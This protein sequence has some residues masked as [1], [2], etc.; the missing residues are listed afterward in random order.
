M[1]DETEGKSSSRDKDY[2]QQKGMREQLSEVY[3]TV[4]KG[5]DDKKSQSD[6]IR[7]CWDVYNCNI[8]DQQAYNGSS[9]VFIPLVHDAVEAQVTRHVNTLFPPTGRAV[10]V[11]SETGDIPHALIAMQEHYVRKAGVRQAVESM[12]RGGYV[13]GQFSLYLSWKERTRFVTSKV[14][15]AAAQTELGT[16]IEGSEFE[17]IDS[18]RELKQ[19]TPDVMVLATEDL[20]ILPATADTIEDAELVAVR[21]RITKAALK[22]KIASGEYSKDAEQ[23]LAQFGATARNQ[24]PDPDKQANDAAGVKVDGATKFAVVYE[25]WTKLKVDGER[26]WCVVDFGGS[27]LVLRCK[28]NPY[29]CD[30]VPVLSLPRAK[31]GGSIWGQSAIAG[32]VEKL[33]YTAND[34]WNMG[35]DSAQYALLPIVMT[36]PEKNPRVGSMVL[37]MAAIWETS[38]NDTKFAAFPQLWKDALQLVAV[39]RDQIMQS[40]SVNPA[41]MPHGNAGKKPSAAQA[42]QET[43]Q[44]VENTAMPVGDLEASILAPMLQWFYDLDAQ[45]RDDELMVETF[46]ELGIQARMQMVPAQQS[47]ERYLFKWYGS[48]GLRSAQQIQQMIA[49]MNVLRGV[50]PDQLGGRRFDIAP[51]M[52]HIVETVFGPRLAPRILIDQRDQLSL[53][54]ALENQMLLNNLPVQVHML[55]DDAQHLQEHNAAAMATGDPQG[56][57]RAHMAQH[58][59][60]LQ[61]KAGGQQGGQPQQGRP[62]PGGAPPPGQTP[63]GAQPGQPRPVQA[64]P[65]AVHRDQMPLAQPRPHGGLA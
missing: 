25:V 15:R 58:L 22:A 6:D 19:G 55:D 56:A 57:F 10:E 7:R 59:Q 62:Q 12:I 14:M 9:K 24:D 42:A 13:S 54:A 51:I 30:R 45:F 37:A 28:R 35:M 44:A 36:D 1:E 26:R 32:G 49:T 65:G 11:V 8:T 17:D 53:P 4:C 33:Q 47:G 34:A 46:G 61:K 38:P 21:K 31:I 52:E 60:Q 3:S 23:L 2:S 39:N 64:P 16:D 48:E 41:M 5:W 27:D 63:P 29:W 50:P 20:L 18:D 40:L 43:Q